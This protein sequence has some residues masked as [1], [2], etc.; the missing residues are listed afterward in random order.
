[1]FLTPGILSPLMDTSLERPSLQSLYPQK[2]HKGKQTSAVDIETF[3]GHPRLHRR[4]R[5]KVPKLMPKRQSPTTQENVFKNTKLQM[6][7]ISAQSLTA[8]SLYPI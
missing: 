7:K 4:G 1:M 5:E 2:S 3:T 8:E 6:S